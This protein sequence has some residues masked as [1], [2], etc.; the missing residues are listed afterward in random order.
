MQIQLEQVYLNT[1]KVNTGNN[2][3]IIKTIRLVK[4]Y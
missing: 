1:S 4:L 2:K 3:K